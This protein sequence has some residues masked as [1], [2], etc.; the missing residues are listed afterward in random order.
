MRH[1]TIITVGSG[2]RSRAA[3]TAAVAAGV[4]IG[5]FRRRHSPIINTAAMSFRPGGQASSQ[6]SQAV[7]DAPGSVWAPATADVTPSSDQTVAVADVD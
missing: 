3:A 6:G 7:A 4:Q 5:V 2:R 1:Q